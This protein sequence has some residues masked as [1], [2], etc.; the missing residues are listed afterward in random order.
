MHRAALLLLA[1]CLTLPPSDGPDFCSAAAPDCPAGES[2]INDVCT[3]P[4]ANPVLHDEDL[5]GLDD[6]CDPCPHVSGDALD[7]D[8]DRVGDVCDPAPLEPR[9][10]IAFFD[11]F[12]TV[13]TGWAY[14]DHGTLVAGALH[15]DAL[16]MPGS[17]DADAVVDLHTQTGE[18]RIALGGTIAGRMSDADVPAIVVEFG[19]KSWLDLHAV[20]IFREATIFE[21]YTTEPTPEPSGKVRLA[22]HAL[23]QQMA[24]GPWSMQIDESVAQQRIAVDARMPGNPAVLGLTA[25][26]TRGRSPLAAND[27][28]RVFVMNLDLRIDYMVLIETAP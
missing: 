12:T 6:A 13:Q 17:E 3:E 22:E 18:L 28:I 1:G 5:D 25:D 27:L 2:C 9:Q 15:V 8:G 7:S 23:D 16:P 21:R 24:L 4:C 14:N 20:E 10:H 26:T 11:A 19:H